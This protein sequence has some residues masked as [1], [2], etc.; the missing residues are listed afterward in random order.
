MTKAKT[1]TPAKP[2][3]SLF[4]FFQKSDKAD[5]APGTAEKPEKSEKDKKDEPVNA[6][7]VVVTPSPVAISKAPVLS[8]DVSIAQLKWFFIA[9]IEL[10]DFFSI[11]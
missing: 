9:V 10:I 2:Q 5:S 8:Q 1:I 7:A 3:K 4:S 6:S 11:F